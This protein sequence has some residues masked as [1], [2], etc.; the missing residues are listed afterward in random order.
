MEFASCAIRQETANDRATLLS[1]CSKNND[2][3]LGHVDKLQNLGME[4]WDSKSD[5]L[6]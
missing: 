2:D 6:D 3:L 4:N 1:G 5:N